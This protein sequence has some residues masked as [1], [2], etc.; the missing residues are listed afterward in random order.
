MYNFCMSLNEIGLSSVS[1]FLFYTRMKEAPVMG[2]V[3]SFEGH[4]FVTCSL[5][6][7]CK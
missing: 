7:S 1:E 5:N 2:F 3:Y 4:M 6:I